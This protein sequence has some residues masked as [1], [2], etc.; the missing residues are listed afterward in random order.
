MVGGGCV[1]EILIFALLGLGRVGGKFVE[2]CAERLFKTIVKMVKIAM[3]F[4]KLNHALF[5]VRKC[6]KFFKTH[7]LYNLFF[8][9]VTLSFLLENPFIYG[10][11]GVFSF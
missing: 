9:L 3:T 4:Q 6:K 10:G 5:E 1:I 11:M 8:L 7:Y 2:I